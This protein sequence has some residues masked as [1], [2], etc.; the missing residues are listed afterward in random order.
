MIFLEL[1]MRVIVEFV[2]FQVHII[3]VVFSIMIMTFL[4]KFC[5]LCIL[6]SYLGVCHNELRHNKCC[7]LVVI[8][9]S[10][11]YLYLVVFFPPKFLVF[12]RRFT[13]MYEFPSF[14]E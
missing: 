14:V 6:F 11:Y 3:D 4:E 7:S 2:F 5:I 10:L 9:V 8:L 12:L 1:P 13:E